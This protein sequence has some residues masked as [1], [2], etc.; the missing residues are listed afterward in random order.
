MASDEF[1]REVVAKTDRRST[2]SVLT[3]V[4]RIAGWVSIVS[5]VREAARLERYSAVLADR[6]G[7]F[8]LKADLDVRVSEAVDGER[9]HVVAAGEDRQVSSR[10]SVD[11]VLTLRE[12]SPTSTLVT[13]EGRYEVVGRVASMGTG[14]ITRKAEKILEEFFERAAVELGGAG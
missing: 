9:L 6:V 14:I 10:L 3:D 12:D 8:K 2:W 11:A 13:I 5:E 7:P 1:R 4:S